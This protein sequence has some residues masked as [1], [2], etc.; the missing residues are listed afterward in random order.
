MSGK[1]PNIL[2]T[3]TPGTGKSTLCQELANRLPSVTHVCVGEVAKANDNFDGW[4]EATQCHFLDEDRLLDDLEE[5]LA[6][7]GC[8]VD[9]HSAEL[10]PERW[11]QAVFV[12]RTENSLLYQRLKARNYAEAKVQQNVQCEI[13]QT[14]LEEARESYKPEIVHE[15]QSN[16]PDDLEANIALIQDWLA[17]NG[18][19]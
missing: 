7:G 12:L 16:G 13:F 10:F 6:D 15:L 1:R 19:L 11:F 5:R 9:Y 3:G 4:D 18:G 17:K 2:V 8:L 14:L